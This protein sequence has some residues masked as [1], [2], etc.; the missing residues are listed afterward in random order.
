M[1]EEV[2][3]GDKGG[4]GREGQQSKGM[5]GRRG[6][7]EGERR[8]PIARLN[9]FLLTLPNTPPFHTRTQQQPQPLPAALR[10]LHTTHPP[11]RSLH[12][13]VVISDGL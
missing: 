4:Q 9:A 10:P 6:D 12:S 7:K 11:P 3:Q 1:Q 2:G 8:A 5:E 13:L